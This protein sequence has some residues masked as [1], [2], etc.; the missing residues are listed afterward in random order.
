MRAKLIQVIV[1][2]M[3]CR[4]KGVESD[5][6]RRI[7]QYWS[8]KGELLAEVDPCNGLEQQSHGIDWKPEDVSEKTLNELLEQRGKL[9]SLVAH[10][11]NA[12]DKDVSVDMKKFIMKE[13]SEI[14]RIGRETP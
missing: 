8:P 13:L 7:T 12:D 4:G 6:C 2:D 3:E 10:V 5:P 14:S 11:Y 9:S 1:T